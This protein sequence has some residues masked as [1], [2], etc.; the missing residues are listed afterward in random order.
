M[1]NDWTPL[2]LLALTSQ[3]VGQGLMIWSLPRFSPLVIGLTL[4]IQP[5]VAALTGWIGFGETLSVIDILGGM[6]V[7]AAL[8]LIRL[9]SRRAEPI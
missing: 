2:V 8:V 5:A 1:P 3:I 4:L 6:M 9:P 7:G